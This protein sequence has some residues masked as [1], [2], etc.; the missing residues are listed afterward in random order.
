MSMKV[1]IFCEK[2]PSKLE[3][4]INEWLKTKSDIHVAHIPCPSSYVSGIPSRA[5]VVALY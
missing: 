3:E 4:S 1:K 2:E 5:E